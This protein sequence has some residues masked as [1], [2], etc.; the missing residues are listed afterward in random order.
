MQVVIRALQATAP[1]V[2]RLKKLVGDDV[3]VVKDDAEL[4]TAIPN[5]ELFLVTDNLYSE[6]MARILRERARNLKWIQL[7]SAGYDAV[8]RHGVPPG[9][10]VTNAGDAYAPAVATQAIALLLG[11]QR[12]FPTLLDNQKRH[13]WDRASS[14]RC[15]IPF[16]STVAVIGFG[17]IGSEIGRILRSFGARI[18][19]VTRQGRP[20]PDAD[21]TALVSDLPTILPR[22]DAI[23]IALAASPESLHLLGTKEF[24]LMKRSA[25]LVNIARGYIVDSVALAQAL[26]N[27]VIAGA[28]VDVTEP[29]PLPEGH[30]LWDAPNLIIA[31]HMAGASGSV[32]SERLAKV[33]GDNVARL[34]AG[35]PLAH[36]VQL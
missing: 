9:V 13:A 34:L 19:A 32:L 20:H 7:L 23:M 3:T 31:P 26:K 15:A 25:I 22:A 14:A 29:E 16:G 6:A 24:A 10:L 33:V 12:Q 5:A 11:V 28:G 27:G 8:A 21:E 30:E 36:I 35:Q 1:I 17:H 2:A 18:I 4:E